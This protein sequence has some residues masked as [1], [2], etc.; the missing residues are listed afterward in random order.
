MSRFVLPTLLLIGSSS[1]FAQK[2]VEGQAQPPRRD[3]AVLE[4]RFRERFEQ[5]LRERVSL[6]DAQ[7]TQLRE[8]NARLDSRR[9]ELFTEERTVRR[10]VREALKGGDDQANQDR[11][12]ELTA[13]ALRVQRSRLDLIETE[14]RELATFLSPIQRARYLGL[15]EQLWRRADDM[16]RRADGERDDDPFDLDSTRGRAP[17]RPFDRRPGR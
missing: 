1:V 6:S 8:V 5:L 2:A 15:Q 17:R 9:R 7:I 12:A 14:Q 10:A 3:R 4:Q 13:R 16:R 11:V